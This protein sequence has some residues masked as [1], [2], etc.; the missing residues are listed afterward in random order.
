MGALETLQRRKLSVSD[1][2]RMGEAG[3][4]G[5]NDRIEL[6]EGEMIEMAPIGA[7]HLSKVNRI[8]RMLI[9][10]VGDA[11]I[12]SIQN[13]IVLL[14]RSEPQPDITVLKPRADDYEHSVPAAADVLLVVEVADT[15]L[16]YDREIKLP[17]YARHDIPEVWLVDLHNDCVIVHRGPSAESYRDVSTVGRN[18]MISPLSLPNVRLDL[19][20]LWRT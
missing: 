4:L 17:L 5:E 8:T 3:I 2:H 11:G 1:F 14:P 13:P 19:A 9:A 16:R 6:I 18:A 15:T 12:V 20:E 7:R 10:A